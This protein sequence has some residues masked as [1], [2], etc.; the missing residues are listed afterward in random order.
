MV[1]SGVSGFMDEGAVVVDVK[2]VY[3]EENARQNGFYYRT[4]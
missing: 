3:G 2:G 4:L 1:F